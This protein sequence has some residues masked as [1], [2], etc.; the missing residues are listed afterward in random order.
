MSE[1]PKTNPDGAPVGAA[2]EDTLQTCGIVM[3]I[4]AIDGCSAEHWVEVRTILEEVAARAGYKP[5]LVS[6]ADDVGIIHQRIVQN[7]AFNPMVI[8]DV[9]AK[10]PNV[11]FELGMRLTFDMPIVV[12]KDD[13]T[14]FSFDTSPIEHIPYPRN[15]RYSRILQFKRELEYKL[16]ATAEKAQ[17]KEA[18]SG[19][20]AAFGQFKIPKVSQTEVPMDQYIASEIVGLREDIKAMGL[21]QSTEASR[22][23]FAKL[24]AGLVIKGSKFAESPTLP[25]LQNSLKE[26]T[27]VLPLVAHRAISTATLREAWDVA[28]EVSE[29]RENDEIPF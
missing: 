14:D 28:R 11:M 4:S 20:L 17:K 29:W 27:G 24:V 8:C 1:N 19:F 10:N 12:I 15:L 7:L 6:F 18:G 2:A 21:K 9:S 3:P 26:V 16:K 13:E 23:N 25:Q 22:V 5:N